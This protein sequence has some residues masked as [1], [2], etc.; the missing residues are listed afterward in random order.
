M[1]VFLLTL[2]G[3]PLSG[4]TFTETI[5]KIISAIQKAV[6]VSTVLFEI[7]GSQLEWLK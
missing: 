1:A 5:A 7:I 4:Q 2:S 6:K 3:R